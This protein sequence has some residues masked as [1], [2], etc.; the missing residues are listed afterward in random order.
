MSGSGLGVSRPASPL[1]DI[2]EARVEQADLATFERMLTQVQ[3]AFVRED[4]AALRELTTPEVMS[5]LAEELGQNAKAGVRNDVSEVKLLQGD[6]SE[7]WHENDLHYATVAMRYEARDVMRDRANG[8]LISGDAE[9]P[10]EVT[11]LWTF[12]RPRAG[13]WKVSAIQEA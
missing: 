12:V 6:V 9:G 5:Y 10:S 7:T 3:N 1:T 13:D 11:E 2:A 8:D 4:Y